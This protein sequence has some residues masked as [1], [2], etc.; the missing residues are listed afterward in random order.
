MTL[1]ENFRNEEELEDFLSAPYPSDIELMRQ[2][3]GDIL[4]LG[5]GGKM[6]PTLAMRACRAAQLAGISK[7]VI[8]VSRFSNQRVAEKLQSQGVTIIRADLLDR[9][10]LQ[11]LPDAPNV[12]YMPARKFGTATDA[13]PTWAINAYLPG[14]IAERFHSSRIVA[15]SSGNVYPLVPLAHGGPD[16]S[17]PADP[18]GEYGYSVLARERV[19]QYFSGLYSTPV[20]LLRLNYAVEMRYGVLVDIALKV[21]RQQPIDVTMGQVNVIWQGDANSYCLQSFK[22]CQSPPAVLNVTGPETL[23]V[24]WIAHRFGRLFNIEPIFQGEEA[25]TALL[26]NATHCHTLF[27]YPRVTPEKMIEWI[28]AWIRRG[29][30][31]WDKPTHFE[32]RDGKF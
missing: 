17:T 16:E 29:G 15:F 30:T 5:A 8:A 18:V 4:I 19:F 22:L 14:L 27:G 24:R 2:L 13:A 28:A 1:P 21:Y 11:N 23:S 7:K 25:S 9:N 12:I 31:I 26:N 6:G 32:V 10:Q 20:T 3:D